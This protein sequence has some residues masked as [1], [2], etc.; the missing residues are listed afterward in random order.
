MRLVLVEVR[1]EVL[2]KAERMRMREM[3]EVE[4]RRIVEELL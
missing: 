3:K 4:S 2:K 1:T